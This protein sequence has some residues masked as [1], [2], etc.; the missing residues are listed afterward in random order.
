M[1]EQLAW[2]DAS[3]TNL[4]KMFHI[5]LTGMSKHI[6]VLVRAGLVTTEKVG[7]VRICRL[8]GPAGRRVAWI[9]HSP[10]FGGLHQRA[11][12]GN[13]EH[14]ATIRKIDERKQGRATLARWPL[15]RP[16][17]FGAWN[18]M[19][20]RPE[21]GALLTNSAVGR[22][23]SSNETLVKRQGRG[24]VPD[25]IG[26]QLGPGAARSSQKRNGCRRAAAAAPSAV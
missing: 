25:T 21:C 23:A 20:K 19:G 26:P 18:R 15:T 5:T 17:A 4:A 7:R 22:E 11:R 16:A 24:F 14:L 9:A 8:G 13:F 2:S 3:I 6:N 1:L 10:A 12:H